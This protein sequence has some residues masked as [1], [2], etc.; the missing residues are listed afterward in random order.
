MKVNSI[1]G[2]VSLPK[3]GFLGLFFLELRTLKK[4]NKNT[5][6]ETPSLPSNI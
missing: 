5:Y 3:S 4:K 2:H 1:R 6:I